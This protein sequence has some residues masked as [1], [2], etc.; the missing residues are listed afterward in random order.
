MSTND[1]AQVWH[2]A[3]QSQTFDHFIIGAFMVVTVIA[4]SGILKRLEQLEQK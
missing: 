4:I 3:W 1:I 2:I